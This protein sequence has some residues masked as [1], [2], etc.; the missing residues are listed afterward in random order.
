MVREPEG[1]LLGVRL[2]AVQLSS[3]IDG[4]LPKEYFVLWEHE[5]IV[6]MFHCGYSLVSTLGSTFFTHFITL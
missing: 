6:Y 2:T 4:A 3:I 1:L 5:G